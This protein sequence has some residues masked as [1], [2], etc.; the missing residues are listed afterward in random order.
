MVDY[1]LDIA[2]ADRRQRGRAHPRAGG[3]LRRRGRRQARRRGDPGRRE[4]IHPAAARDRPDRRGA[5]RGLRRRPPDGRPRPGHAGG[6]RARRPGRAVRS[7]DPDHRRER[8]R[9]GGDGPLRAQ[10]VASARRGP[11]SRV[12]CAAIP[13]N[14]LE[15][16]LFGHEKGAFTG[17]VGAADRQVRGGRP[18][19]RCCSTKSPRWTG[20]CRPSCCAPC[21][22][23][24]STASAAASR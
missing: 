23:G 19:A 2:G 3:S 17:A 7:L 5:G 14:L 21:R 20:G 18:A 4:G 16:E 8:R 15:S 10:E 22:S 12:N 1:E 11:S 24:R 9:Q 6:D 13:E